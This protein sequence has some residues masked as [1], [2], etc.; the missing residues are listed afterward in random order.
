MDCPYDN[1]SFLPAD[2][3]DRI[4]TELK[5]QR[6]WRRDG[7]ALRQLNK[8]WCLQVSQH[9]FEINPHSS[10]RLEERDVHSLTKFPQLTGLNVS[11]FF[12]AS[13][14]NAA[15]L[16]DA[17]SMISGLRQLEVTRIGL[18]KLEGAGLSRMTGI[19]SLSCTDRHFCK[20]DKGLTKLSLEEFKCRCSTNG[21]AHVVRKLP[22]LKHLN[23]VIVS[24]SESD[25]DDAEVQLL[26]TLE[27]LSLDMSK[28]EYCPAEKLSQI[29]SLVSLCAYPQHD[30]EVE[31][32]MQLPLLKHLSIRIRNANF[33]LSK[34]FNQMLT[35]LSSLSLTGY[36][37]EF[38]GFTEK[39]DN[40]RRLQLR[41]FCLRDARVF[42]DLTSLTGLSLT[43]CV[44]EIPLNYLSQIRLLKQLELE[45]RTACQVAN[46]CNEDCLVLNHQSFPEL[47]D[48]R[49]AVKQNWSDWIHMI[50]GL[51]RLE[52]LS[53]DFYFKLAMKT[54]DLSQLAR[55]ANL[56]SLEIQNLTVTDALDWNLYKEFWAQLES[57]R[58]TRSTYRFNPY[59]IHF[60]SFLKTCSPHLKVCS[61]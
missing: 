28:V 29:T 13:E 16:M 52:T 4:V 30:A 31:G 45:L 44:C 46:G 57:L 14:G 32:L 15:K 53:L 7:R 10:R 55:L 19:K 6:F 49:V 47:T 24:V 42:Q 17:I 40:L 43:H 18:K 50:A 21:L 33:L 23:A 27:S 8:H 41:E 48:L 5:R 22:H 54:E 37:L 34:V 61:I 59:L 11:K 38:K 51:S 2:F 56:R 26:N 25:L 3:V 35:R 9:I 39:V 20:L 58:V 60:L 12:E 36:N 1:W